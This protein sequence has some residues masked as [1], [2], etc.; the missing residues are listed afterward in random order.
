MMR[1]KS[2][3]YRCASQER[4]YDNCAQ[5]TYCTG[6]LLDRTFYLYR[7]HFAL[8]V[9]IFALPELCSLAVHFVNLALK[10]PGAKIYIVLWAMVLVLEEL[11]VSAV[12]QAATVM[13]ISRVY[14]DRPASVM[15]S[16]SRVKNK[17]LA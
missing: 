12:A 2:T 14:L 9:G 16:F 7:N 8:F 11:A 1:D 3:C 17:I 5:A 15:D 13:A 4:P 10:T 6:E